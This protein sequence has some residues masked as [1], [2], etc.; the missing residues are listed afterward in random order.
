MC[1]IFIFDISEIPIHLYQWTFVCFSVDQKTN[2]KMCAWFT[3][4]TAVSVDTLSTF[5]PT[6]TLDNDYDLLNLVKRGQKHDDEPLSAVGEK[7]QKD[8]AT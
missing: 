4:Q 2:V 3:Q 5:G 7:K 6:L 8:V 1:I